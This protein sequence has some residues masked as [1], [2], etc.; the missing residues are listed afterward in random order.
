M[1]RDEE[2][3]NLRLFDIRTIERNIRKGLTTRKD[4]EKILKTLEDVSDKIAPK[5]A[6]SSSIAPS[7]PRPVEYQAA[8]I[9]AIPPAPGSAELRMEDDIDD[10]EDDDDIEELDDDDLEP[11]SNGAN[12]EPPKT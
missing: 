6:P 4:Y 1:S 3:K 12:E 11:A 2:A 9:I 5:D 10:D 7:T 8:P